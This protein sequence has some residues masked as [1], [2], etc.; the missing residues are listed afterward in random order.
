MNSLT[1][2]SELKSSN[3]TREAQGKTLYMRTHR[4]KLGRNVHTITRGAKNRRETPNK[5]NEKGV[6]YKSKNLKKAKHKMKEISGMIACEDMK[7][8]Q[9]FK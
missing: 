2:K 6:H 4:N 5:Q 3:V 1:S 9:K 7:R 8:C